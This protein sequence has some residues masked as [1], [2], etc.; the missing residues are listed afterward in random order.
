MAP[1]MILCYLGP[2]DRGLSSEFV[3]LVLLAFADAQ[4]IRFMQAVDLVLVRL[5]LTVNSSKQLQLFSVLSQCLLGK[6][7][8]Q[9]TDEHPAHSPDPL[10]DLFAFD[11]LAQQIWQFPSEAATQGDVGP[12]GDLP[13][14]L[15]DLAQE[16]QVRGK[17]N[18]LL[19][20]QWYPPQPRP[21]WPLCH[22]FALKASKIKRVPSSPIRFR[23]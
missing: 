5:L 12:L 19:L 1:T 6:F 4:H 2:N 20:R 18:V 3:L 15:D 16:L 11:P 17:R 22:V 21:P 8:F 9:F 7:A 13:A 23:K 10:D 14:L